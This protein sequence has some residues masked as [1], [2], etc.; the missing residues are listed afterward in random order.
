MVNGCVFRI[1]KFTE[2]IT[3]D[4]MKFEILLKEKAPLF[5]EALIYLM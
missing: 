2:N 3:I 1:I 4:K 5:G